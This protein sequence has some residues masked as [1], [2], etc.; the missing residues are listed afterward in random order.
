MQH[1]IFGPGGGGGEVE[2]MRS[3]IMTSLYCPYIAG[4]VQFFC[5]QTR[6]HIDHFLPVP[7]MR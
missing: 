6:L 5:K 1:F 7:K 3:I 2:E 4:N